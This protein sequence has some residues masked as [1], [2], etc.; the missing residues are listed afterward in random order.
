MPSRCPDGIVEAHHRTSRFW[1]RHASPASLVLLGLL[2][3]AALAGL[4][5][6]QP[7][8]RMVRE[9]STVRLEVDISNVVRNGV[10]FETRIRITPKR[11]VGA[12]V[13]GISPALWRDLTITSMMPAASGEESR[14]GLFRFEYGPAPAGETVEIKIDGQVNPEL[15]GGTRGDIVVLDGDVELVRLPSRIEVRP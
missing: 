12:L 3:A 9:T 4:L 10:F 15:F 7:K 5:G 13:L 11:P 14:D 1:G 2:I 6:G 8:A